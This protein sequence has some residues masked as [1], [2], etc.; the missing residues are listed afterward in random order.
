VDKKEVR[1]KIGELWLR[2]E[3]EAHGIPHKEAPLLNEIIA[4]CKEHGLTHFDCD[5]ANTRLKELGEHAQR[6]KGKAKTD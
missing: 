6:G 4:L 5:R 3:S 2:I 1:R